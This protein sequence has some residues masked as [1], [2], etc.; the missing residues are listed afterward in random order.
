VRVDKKKNKELLALPRHERCKVYGD[1]CPGYSWEL[2]TK[3]KGDPYQAIKQLFVAQQPHKRTLIHCDYLVSVVHFLSLADAIGPAEFNKRLKAYGVDKIRLRWNAFYDLEE[4]I[5]QAV[6]AGQLTTLKIVHLGSLQRIAPSSEAD[7]VIGDHVVFFN[8]LA[9]DPLN[10]NIG[11][12]WRLE[13][14][15]LIGK[16]AK[17]ADIFLGHGSGRRTGDQLRSKLAE[18][19]NDVAKIAL[20]LVEKTKS[21]A[22]KIHAQG[23]S[24]LATKFPRVKQ[25]GAE[26]HIQ[27]PAGLCSGK[28]VDEKLRLIKPSEVIGLRDPCDPLKMNP[29]HRTIE[30]EK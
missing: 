14:A 26:W 21:K 30:S 6:I 16:G 19:F 18:E 17:G 8:H 23:L 2:T 9:Y 11:N 20:A 29:V 1:Q 22:P 4:S 3:G 15:V 24:D 5:Y 13:N 27:G 12:A 7:L 10:Q 28:T 25:V